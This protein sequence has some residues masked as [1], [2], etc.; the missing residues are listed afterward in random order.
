MAMNVPPQRLRLSGDCDYDAAGELLQHLYGKLEAPETEIK[1]E[2]VETN[3]PG[4]AAAGLLEKAYLFVPF[5]CN[6]AGQPCKAHLVLHGC[7]QST[8]QIGTVFIDQ[9]G[10]LSLGRSQ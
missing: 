5:A 1:T 7:A 6:N 2:L 4:A 9:S 3:L 10:Y 8:A